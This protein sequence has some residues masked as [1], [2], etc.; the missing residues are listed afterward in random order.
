LDTVEEELVIRPE[1]DSVAWQR[2]GKAIFPIRLFTW[3][4]KWYSRIW[5]LIRL[6][7]FIVFTLTIPIVESEDDEGEGGGEEEEGGQQEIASD[8]NWSQYLHVIQ[9]F[10]EFPLDLGT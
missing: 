10:K 4:T 2:L 6:P 1:E 9:V 7:Y 5:E 8:K 3:R